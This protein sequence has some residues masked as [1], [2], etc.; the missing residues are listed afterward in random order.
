MASRF[1]RLLVVSLA[2]A[3]LATVVNVSPASAATFSRAQIGVTQDELMTNCT[4]PAGILS[5]SVGGLGRTLDI[6]C[7]GA[8]VT[9]ITVTANNQGNDRL[10]TRTVNCPVAGGTPV[11]VGPPPPPPPPPTTIPVGSAG[12]VV[13]GVLAR[14]A[15]GPFGTFIAAL[16]APLMVAFGCLSG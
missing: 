9:V 11:L 1:R 10:V 3:A 12:P 13:C 7:V 15:G 14:L 5:C 8:G 16:L 2:L 6:V 4:E